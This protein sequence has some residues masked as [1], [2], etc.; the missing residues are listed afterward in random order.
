MSARRIPSLTNQAFFLIVARFIGFVISLAL[1]MLLARVM[2]QR[3][4]GLF[5]QAFL[6]TTTL[7]GISLALRPGDVSGADA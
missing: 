5:K 3:E 7:V 1:P 6:I 4:Y 2:S